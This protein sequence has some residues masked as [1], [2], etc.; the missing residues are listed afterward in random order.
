MARR[1]NYRFERSERE[2]LKAA[3]QAARLDE[4]QRQSE[5]RRAARETSGG[6]TPADEPTV[7]P[8]PPA[9]DKE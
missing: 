7:P 1:P 5:E 9:A 6:A 2:R 3:K 8:V 4:K